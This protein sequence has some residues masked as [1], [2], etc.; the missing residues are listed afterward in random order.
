LQFALTPEQ[1]LLQDA[2][3]AFVRDHNGTDQRRADLAGLKGY[4]NDHWRALADV[5]VL[6]LPFAA[7]EGGLGGGPRE[8]VTV[9]ES[10]GRG[11][12]IEPILEEIVLAA[13]VL[14]RA[15]DTAQKEAWL[16]GV[17][18][19]SGTLRSPILSIR[20]ASI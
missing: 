6:G 4:S 18:R 10:L 12:C 8:L 9:M 1:T 2:I 14:A 5:G 17:I 3:D 7:E 11:L 20:R 15:G 16:P 13:G 19:G